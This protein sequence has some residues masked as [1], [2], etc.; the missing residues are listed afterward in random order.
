MWISPTTLTA[1]DACDAARR[2]LIGFAARPSRVSTSAEERRADK[3]AVRRQSLRDLMVTEDRLYLKKLKEMQLCRLSQVDSIKIFKCWFQPLRQLLV[4]IC[5]LLRKSL[6]T[7]LR[8]FFSLMASAIIF[9]IFLSP[10]DDV[11]THI[12]LALMSQTASKPQRI[13][14]DQTATAA[15]AHQAPAIR[16]I[17]KLFCICLCVYVC[18]CVYVYVYMYMCMCCTLLAHNVSP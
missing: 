5:Q 18:I 9:F 10:M 14:V 4:N 6:A 15:A 2:P 1:A 16:I 17:I 7:S 3:M 8:L 13:S 11:I 12:L